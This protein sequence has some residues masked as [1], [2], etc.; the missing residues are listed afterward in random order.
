[1]G[2]FLPDQTAEIVVE[3]FVDRFIYILG[4]PKVILTDQ[5]RNFISE[6]MK[7][8]ARLFRIRKLRTTAFHSQ[9]NESLER[10]QHWA[11]I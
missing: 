4:T 9:S 3:V 11:N 1:M 7:K 6:L 5:G 10:S 2:I 8:I